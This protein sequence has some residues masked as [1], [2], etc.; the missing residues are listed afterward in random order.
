MSTLDPEDALAGPL[1]LLAAMLV[2]VPLVDFVLTVPPPE[3]TNVQWRFNALGLLSG[4]TLLPALGAGVALVVS[5]FTKQYA[6]QRVLV[7]V[8]L[9]T[10]AAF[11]LLSIAFFRDM[12]DARAYV[13]ADG[14][15]AFS[16]ASTRALIKLVLTSVVL[17]YL[18]WRARR[19]IP[20]PVHHK[21]P[22][23]VHVVSK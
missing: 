11:L 20:A 6:L 22:K 7:I 5:A 17:G 15:P 4:Y 16:S 10:A 12:D 23:P 21:T 14:M 18:G 3:P 2:G 9:T 8:C 19:M 1:Y 13:T